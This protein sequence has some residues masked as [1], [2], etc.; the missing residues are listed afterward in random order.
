M[1]AQLGDI[2]FEGLRGFNKFQRTRETV[3]AQV[4]MVNSKPRIQKTGQKLDEIDLGI[5]LH[6]EFCVPENEL[7]KFDKAR[8]KGEILTLMLGNGAV[9]GGFLVVSL[10]E[11]IRKTDKIGNVIFL[12]LDIKLIE[13]PLPDRK[14]SIALQA[15]EQAF[16]L[17]AEKVVPLRRAAIE[18][19]IAYDA[20][21]YENTISIAASQINKDVDVANRIPSQRPALFEKISEATQKVS[22]AA[23][24]MSEKVRAVQ[25][26]ID[27]LAQILTDIDDTA[28]FVSDLSTAVES[29]DI[30]QVVASNNTFQSAADSLRITSSTMVVLIAA[31]EI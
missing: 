3:Y 30:N 31:R 7:E 5:M 17:D 21:K 4:P 24:E 26:E 19:T 1:Y 8:K 14:A 29:G 2:K 27:N 11:N 25:E 28:R 13:H 6:S 20:L 16:A 12:E 9:V 15:Q 22:E 23:L 10:S 18:P